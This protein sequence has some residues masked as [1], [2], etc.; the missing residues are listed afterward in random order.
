L[1]RP[2]T[3]ETDEATRKT[4]KTAGIGIVESADRL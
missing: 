4:L 3:P 1:T 2:V